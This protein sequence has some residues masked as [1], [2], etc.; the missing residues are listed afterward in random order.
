LMQPHDLPR[1]RLIERM[2]DGNR[3]NS[4]AEQI[5]DGM[6]CVHEAINAEEKDLGL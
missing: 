3:R 2:S 4:I 1:L 6:G 5:G